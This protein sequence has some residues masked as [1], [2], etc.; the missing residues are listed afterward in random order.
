[1]QVRARRELARV[2]AVLVHRKIMLVENFVLAVLC[3]AAL[4]RKIGNLI[5]RNTL[6]RILNQCKSLV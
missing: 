1:M 5:Y 3:V 2:I 4:D 6:V